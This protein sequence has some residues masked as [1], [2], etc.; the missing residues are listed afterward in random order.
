MG[1]R[2][3]LA[4]LIRDDETEIIS[5]G[6]MYFSASLT[7]FLA[8]AGRRMKEEILLPLTSSMGFSFVR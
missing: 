4:K 5:R 1:P 6:A 2:F 7:F 8:E 3:H